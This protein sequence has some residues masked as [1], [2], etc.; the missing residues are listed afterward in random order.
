MLLHIKVAIKPL[1]FNTKPTK[2]CSKIHKKESPSSSSFNGNLT[3]T[4][5]D[6]LDSPSIDTTSQ[7][8]S[9]L[10]LAKVPFN[11]DGM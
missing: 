7:L 2:V 10:T 3:T 9:Q 1:S 11:I 8:T 4:A 6:I 5:P